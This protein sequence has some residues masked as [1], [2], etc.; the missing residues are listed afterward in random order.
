METRK[1]R[2]ILRSRE[3][4][5]KIRTGTIHSAGSDSRQTER[6]QTSQRRIL[7]T[8]NPRRGGIT[9]ATV[10]AAF[11]EVGL[12]CVANTYVLGPERTREQVNFLGQLQRWSAQGR[13]AD[14]NLSNV[15][16][17]SE[18]LGQDLVTNVVM[19]TREYMD[20]LFLQM[21]AGSL[22]A[23]YIVQHIAGIMP[24]VSTIVSTMANTDER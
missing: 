1:R 24:S 2:L 16:D 8:L 21:K 6:N 3:V 9:V 7:D 12:S 17:L 5:D 13:E 20:Q 10:R 14:N 18:Q 4:A 23:D 11:K 22:I 19:V 15:V